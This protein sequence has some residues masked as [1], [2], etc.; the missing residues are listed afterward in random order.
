MK[1]FAIW[2]IVGFVVS[3]VLVYSYISV[4]KTVGES[5]RIIR[6]LKDTE[7]IL[8]SELEETRKKLDMLHKENL[9]LK[10]KTDRIIKE[11]LVTIRRLEDENRELSQRIR[12]KDDEIRRVASELRR[13]SDE[14]LAPRA[15]EGIR[16]IYPELDP[17]VAFRGTESLFRFGSNRD[18]VEGSARAAEELK[19]EREINSL[20]NRKVENLV[21]QNLLLSGSLSE[22]MELNRALAEEIRLS[23]KTISDLGSINDNLTEQIHELESQNRRL[24][25][26]LFWEKV[27]TFG[28]FAAGV[29]AGIIISR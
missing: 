13:T 26:K 16:N 23:R 10:E 28:G 18:F 4:R 5:E 21:N 27:K 14:E 17:E 15:E 22:S 11:N 24:K 3:T 9:S 8:R 29:V 1:R 19:R 12:E 7:K 20:L 6:Q 25:R 2:F